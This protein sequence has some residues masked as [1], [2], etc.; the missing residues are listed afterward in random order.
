M[1]T[2]RRFPKRP[3]F[4][5]FGAMGDLAWRLIGPALFNLHL[6]GQLPPGFSLVGVDRDASPDTLRERI[7][8]GVQRYS[9]RGGPQDEAWR[10]FAERLDACAM[11]L[12]EPPQYQQLRERLDTPEGGAD[13]RIF[14]LA[15]PP[16]LF[17]AV[18]DGLAHAGLHRDRGRARI[19]V[20]KPLGD[21]LA[22]FQ[23]IDRTLRAHFEEGQIYRMD[24]FLGK[25]TVQNILALRFANPIFEPVWN[26]RYIDHVTVTVAERIGV[27]HRAGYYEQAGALRDMVQNHLMQLMCL[28]AMEAPVA[29]DAEDIRNK[30]LD[31]L[32]A[33][34]PIPADNVTA[35][36][37]RGQYAAGWIEGEHVA[38]Y[39]QEP[40]IDAYSNTETYAAIK[41][42]VD[43][44]RWQD[45]PFYLR[46]GKRMTE[47]VSEISIRFR[48][49]P[50]NAFPA[51]TGL[52][53][54]PVRLV[55]Q[56]QPQEGVILKFMAK[57][58]GNPLRL[59]PV[60]MRFSYR[61]AFGKDSP[62]AYETLLRDL[63]LGDATLF[64]RSDQVEEA[65][66][67][68]TPVLEAWAAN[69]AP[70]FPNYAAGGWGPE[71]AERLIARDGRAW[72]TPSQ[73]AGE[74]D[75]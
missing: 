39:R 44:W 24:H 34:R 52:N 28:V 73:R 46:T 6:D 8:D 5:L 22:A 72:L 13:A 50:H 31:V 65:W 15:I 68:L 54:Q 37:V 63:M 18:A 40:G 62:E 38:A 27:G 49:V 55:I 32:R 7:R 67:L 21:S 35:F 69:P 74:Q 61:E 56:I 1:N 4:V 42:L 20:E 9:R 26:R 75:D 47:T 29:Y 33:C 36:A 30:K 3:Q 53:A 16:T 45:V 41:L 66:R 59:G 17:G 70:D 11:D 51:A 14:Y 10:T 25:E 58:P 57:E 64:M 60:N 12:R 43:N 23:D 2:S 19:V 71:A 48:D